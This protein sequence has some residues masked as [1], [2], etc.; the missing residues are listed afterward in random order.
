MPNY[1]RREGSITHVDTPDGHRYF[2]ISDREFSDCGRAS[3]YQYCNHVCRCDACRDIHKAAESRRRKQRAR[4]RRTAN[5]SRE[6]SQG[7][8][9]ISAAELRDWLRE[10]RGDA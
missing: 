7:S 2:I 1:E 5:P 9:R 4:N 8:G 10:V 6:A 3:E